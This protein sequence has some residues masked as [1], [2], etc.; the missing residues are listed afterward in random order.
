[1]STAIIPHG[2]R[3]DP[4][5][6]SRPRV[7]SNFL[8]KD[9]YAAWSGKLQIQ[10]NIHKVWDVVNGTRLCPIV[11]TEIYNPEGT[12]VTNQAA[13]NNAEQRVQ[14]Y[15]DAFNKAAGIIAETISDSQ[16][17]VVRSTLGNPILT[18]KKLQEKFE[19][20]SKAEFSAAQLELL[21]FEHQ[22]SQSANETI[23][24]YEMIIE[25]CQQ[26]GVPAPDDLLQQMLLARPNDRYLVRIRAR[27]N[28]VLVLSCPHGRLLCPGTN[29]FCPYGS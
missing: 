26:Q 12:V 24:R 25:R 8:G 10:L 5:E 4:P 20:R 3:A 1:M 15:T 23:E 29:M 17:Y 2:I 13:I 16:I 28:I 22:E 18:W 27:P 19:R 6:G 9:N 14:S 11:P 7:H 21:S